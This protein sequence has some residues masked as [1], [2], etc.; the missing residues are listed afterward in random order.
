MNEALL[1]YPACDL[2]KETKSHELFRKRDTSRSWLAKC[3]TDPSLDSQMLFPIVRCDGCGHVFVKPR[4]KSEVANEI[5]ERF[6]RIYEPECLKTTQYTDYVSRQLSELVTTG[7]RLLDFGCGWGSYLASAQEAGWHATGIEVDATN[8][9][10]ATRHGLHAVQGDLLDGIFEAEQFDAVIAQQ[11]FEHLL[12]PVEYLR[13]IHRLLKPGGVLAIA[14]PNLGG[15][16]ARISGTDWEMITP[17]GHVRYFDSSSLA[18]F[19]SDNGF[20][21]LEKR[22]V[23]RFEN[24]PIKNM[25]FSM[26]GGARKQ[27]GRVSE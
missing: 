16:S 20:E 27:A 15:L 6:W 10:F 24:S 5:Y 13:E 7:V 14:V 23:Q 11:V 1:E 17:I 21:I 18:K 25:F 2:C 26:P 4:I 3:D 12:N 22:Y 8:V 9:E 19:L